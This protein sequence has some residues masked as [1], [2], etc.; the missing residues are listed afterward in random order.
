MK[1]TASEQIFLRNPKC[2]ADF[3]KNI[4]S[5]IITKLIYQKLYYY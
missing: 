1:T 5:G 2:P 4:R 3:A